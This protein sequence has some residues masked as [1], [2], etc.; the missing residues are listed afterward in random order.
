MPP[1][2]DDL[3]RELHVECLAGAQAGGA[4]EVANG[5]THQAETTSPGTTTNRIWVASSVYRSG[6]RGEVD[7]VEEV[8]IS[9]RSCTLKRSRMGMFLKTDRSTLPKPGP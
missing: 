9:A 1:L 2:E 6:P 4:V 8:K 5:V 3:G 7:P